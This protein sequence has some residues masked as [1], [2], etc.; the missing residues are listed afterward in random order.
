MTKFTKRLI[1][2]LAVIGASALPAIAEDFPTGPVTLIAP[3]SPGGASDVLARTLADSMSKSL[4]QPVV[5]ESKPG[6][7]GTI[8]IGLTA[9]AK[10]DGYTM[11]LGGNGSLV[12]T[13]GVYDLNY[14]VR[15]DLRPVGMVA[16]AQSALVVNTASEFDNFAGFLERAKQEPPLIYG[17]PGVGSA[18]HLAGELFQELTGVKLTHVPYQ[19]LVPALTDLQAGNIDL[20]FAN[21]TSLPP[22]LDG[23]KVVPLAVIDDEQSDQL[24]GIPTAEEEGIEGMAMNTWYGVMVPA[25]TDEVIVEKL[26]AAIADFANSAESIE[27]LKA[28]GFNPT[29]DSSTETFQATLDEDFATWLPLIERLGIRK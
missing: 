20:V 22:Y 27:T 9:A 24:P 12:F 8:G 13:A 15:T 21:I 1:A 11:V 28:M 6:A 17:S 18:L 4:G 3:F 19:G 25:E 7:S 10:P 14:D 29:K 23:G 26:E 2:L 5:V 16:N